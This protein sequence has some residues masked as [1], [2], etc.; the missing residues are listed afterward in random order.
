MP[1]PK[2]HRSGL[3]HSFCAVMK[4]LS[5]GLPPHEGHVLTNARRRPYV[6]FVAS[7]LLVYQDWRHTDCLAATGLPNL[8]T[9]K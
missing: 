4:A 9:I 1:W 2:A 3:I 6:L 8:A 7:L 5:S